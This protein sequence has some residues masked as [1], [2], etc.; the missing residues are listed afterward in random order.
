MGDVMLVYKVMPQDPE[1]DLEAIKKKI[2]EVVSSRGEL[3]GTKEEK[4]AFGLKAVI[5][6][7]VIPDE[8]G[9]VDEMEEEIRAI[10]GIQSAEA[11]DVTLI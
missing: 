9:I 6:T 11:V 7:V 1:E 2:G 10:D 8:G 5:A 4:V 3:R